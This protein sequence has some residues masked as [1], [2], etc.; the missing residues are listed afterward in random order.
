VPTTIIHAPRFNELTVTDI[1]NTILQTREALLR[2]TIL[3]NSIGFP[4]VTIP[5]GLTKD[6]MPIGVQII[7]PPFAEG[8]ILSVAYNYEYKNRKRINF[9]PHYPF[10]C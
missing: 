6:N 9:I 3:F 8:K 1:G 5:I 4:A 10:Y 2:N 7:G